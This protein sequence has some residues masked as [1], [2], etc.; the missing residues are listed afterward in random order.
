MTHKMS[1]L[2]GHV[3]RVLRYDPELQSDQEKWYTMD[4]ILARCPLKHRTS[5]EAMFNSAI[6]E[7]NEQGDRFEK[8]EDPSAMDDSTRPKFMYRR[9][10][11]DLLRHPA[12]VQA[13][14]PL[15]ISKAMMHA[16]RRD[17]SSHSC[18]SL[19][20]YQHL[21]AQGILEENVTFADVY[22]IAQVDKIHYT[23]LQAEGGGSV[24]QAN[25][26]K[27]GGRKVYLTPAAIADGATRSRPSW[28]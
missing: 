17:F 18:D 20:L 10:A 9:S 4:E 5:T 2:A 23:V 3:Q 26:I 21:R 12:T 15:S 22:R 13:T 14:D 25:Y 1:S 19:A 7:C 6:D 8:W 28:S 27:V 24:I 16:L 11:L